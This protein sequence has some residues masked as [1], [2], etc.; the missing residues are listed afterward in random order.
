MGPKDAQSEIK[1]KLFNPFPGQ[2]AMVK[3]Q[4]RGPGIRVNFYLGM[5][6]CL[7]AI[8]YYTSPKLCPV[9]MIL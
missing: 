7:S 5:V 3:G 8:A 1:V 4:P 9:Q 2:P 6:P